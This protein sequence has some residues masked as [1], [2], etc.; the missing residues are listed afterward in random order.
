LPSFRLSSTAQEDIVQI[1]AYTEKRFGDTAR[2]R[3]E[4]LLVT[5]LRDIASDPE[6][7]GSAARPE[8]G[9]MVRSYH[10][11]HRSDRARTQD[12]L[13][14]QPRHLL[15]YRA[16]RTDLTGIGRV[17]HDGME[18]EAHLPSQYGDE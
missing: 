15:L 6:R 11:R 1:P 13:V 2:R 7:E 8:P 9:L 5:S 18:I 4:V 12:G 10:L 14:R 17:L 16:M 3:Y